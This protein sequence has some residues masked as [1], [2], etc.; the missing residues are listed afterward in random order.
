MSRHYFTPTNFPVV[1]S[2]ECFQPAVSAEFF[3]HD[4]P[5]SFLWVLLSDAAR[6]LNLKDTLTAAG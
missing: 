6:E 3:R 1:P 2:D 5:S 4:Q